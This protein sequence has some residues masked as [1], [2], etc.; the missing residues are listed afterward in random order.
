MEP[1]KIKLAKR[2]QFLKASEIRELLKFTQKP[3]IISFAGGLPAAE[4]FPAAEL[5]EVTRQVLQTEGGRAL[6]YST[7][8]GDPALRRQIAGRMNAKQGARV[9]ADDL[10]ITSGSQQGLDFAGKALL[11]EGDV[12]L[13]ESPTYL[14]AIN[15]FLAYQ[16]RFVDVATDDEG[17]I[18]EALAQALEQNPRV[19]FIYVIPDF[20]NPSG[21][22]WSLAR[23]Q[24]LVDLARLRG[25]PIV[26]D[27]PYSELRFEGEPLP[28][29]K[30]LDR[31]DNV[32][33]L[34]TFSKIF[35]P[36]LRC[37][38]LAAP[39]ELQRKFV[40]IKQGADLHTSTLVQRQIATYLERHD[41][42]A[43]VGKV[44][45]VYRERRDRMVEVLAR[46]LPAGVRFTRP[47]GGLF[48]WV[49]FPEHV[50]GRALLER[51]LEHDVAF[52]PGGAF[53]PNGGHENTARL[54]FSFMSLDRIEE[55]VRRFCRVVRQ[56][57]G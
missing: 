56:A 7:T 30:A 14:G 3:E 37:A 39:R 23:R 32:I 15:A 46:E 33:Y 45:G 1:G 48:L 38:W 11:D 8:E 53:F 51:C 17:M 43:N 44:I 10:L 57:L 13:T 49:T 6:Q 24:A 9:E 16:P 55:G 20:Q 4:L 22:T 31:G 50:N 54:N 5:A 47:Q 52:V 35:C 41:L 28:S 19:K 12:V 26:E 42:D 18:P 36:G 34:G 25:V 40:L 21:R 27:G 2:M 29:L